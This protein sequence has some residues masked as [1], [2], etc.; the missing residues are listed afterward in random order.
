MGL[1][2]KAPRTAA[3]LKHAIVLN[4]QATRGGQAIAR[5]DISSQ[6]AYLGGKFGQI[7]NE[8]IERVFT[9]QCSIPQCRGLLEP[10]I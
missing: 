7:G 6:R 10:I 1:V 5:G 4:V 3:Q 2:S 9:L 8:R